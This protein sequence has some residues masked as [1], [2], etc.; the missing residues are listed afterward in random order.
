M[1]NILDLELLSNILVLC[2]VLGI[3]VTAILL[4]LPP[5]K[6]KEFV[7]VGTC[8]ECKTHHVKLYNYKG[9][10]RCEECDEIVK[11]LRG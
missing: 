10:F 3:I 1:S 5:F 9:V 8:L 11:S 6:K 2:L 4:A 7:G